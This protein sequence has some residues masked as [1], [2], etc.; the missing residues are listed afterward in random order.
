MLLAVDVFESELELEAVCV[1]VGEP[2]DEALLL[3]DAVGE[4]VDV[5][6]AEEDD[7]PLPDVLMVRVGVLVGEPVADEVS[8]ADKDADDD[9]V[10]VGVALEVAE[11]DAEGVIDEVPVVLSDPEFDAV[12]VTVDELDD[13]AVD[14]EEVEALVLSVLVA[15]ALLLELSEVLT[16]DEGMAVAVSEAES[17][18]DDDVVAE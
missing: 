15:V 1:V 5:D 4:P 7:E 18:A 11:G 2:D 13:D 10:S 17:V 16:V 9:D 6:V 12:F 3:P 8:E 14:E